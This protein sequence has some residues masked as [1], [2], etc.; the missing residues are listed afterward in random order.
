[1]KQVYYIGLD[2]HKSTIAFCIKQA[3]GQTV[4]AGTI[5]S[6]R[7]ALG[8]WVLQRTHPWIG[9]MEATMFTGWI[10]DFLRPHAVELKVAHP[11]MLEAISKSKKKNDRADAAMLADLLRCGLMPESYMSRSEIRELR[12]LLRYRNFLVKMSV[13]TKNR[14]ACLLMEVGAEYSKR[15]L[16]G[17]RYFESLLETIEDVPESVLELLHMSRTNLELFQTAQKRLIH[18]L[19]EDPRIAQRVRCLCTIPGIGE[20]TALTWVLE[21]DDPFRF[22]SVGRA[23]SYCGLTSAQRESGG[24]ER[25]GPLSK[26]RN[27]HLQ[28]TIIEAAKLAP[29]WNAALADVHA[30]ER[31]R[32]HRNRATLAVARKL[33]AY[34]LAV[35]KR[36]TEF[37]ETR[38]IRAA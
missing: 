8:A 13:Q 6:N 7:N 3:S 37:E 16:H 20:V 2:V 29:R 4:Q 25:R 10:Y 1:M 30:R 5:S 27:P 17:R 11:Y 31:E 38:T 33:V 24:K 28:T 35:D 32:G 18:A 9:G 14:M 23:L 19:K 15:R 21:I 36:G 12:R 26:Q 22:P 34:M